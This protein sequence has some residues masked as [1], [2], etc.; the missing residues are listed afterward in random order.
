MWILFNLIF[1][2]I[3]DLFDY[4]TVS[5]F[6]S[7]IQTP[8]V[9]ESG[10]QVG[11]MKNHSEFDRSVE[12]LPSLIRAGIGTIIQ[13]FIGFGLVVLQLTILIVYI[14]FNCL[15][16][17]SWIACAFLCGNECHLEYFFNGLE[18]RKLNNT[19]GLNFMAFTVYFCALID[20]L[21]KN[22]EHML[23]F[24][25]IS[26]LIS[27]RKQLDFAQ[28]YNAIF[29]QVVFHHMYQFASFIV[30]ICNIFNSS[31]IDESTLYHIL[32]YFLDIIFYVFLL[33]NMV[34]P[35]SLQDGIYLHGT[36]HRGIIIGQ[37]QQG[38]QRSDGQDNNWRKNRG[39]RPYGIGTGRGAFGFQN[40]AYQQ[41]EIPQ[42][43]SFRGGFNGGAAVAHPYGRPVVT[44]PNDVYDQQ[45]D[46]QHDV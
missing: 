26:V 22:F 2:A 32:C 3:L 21:L 37:G 6:S 46:D 10:S 31:I 12:L 34:V 14:Q 24:L 7:E 4:L 30:M 39:R 38:Y 15:D 17:K 11:I 41:Q 20:D 5:N 45:A 36:S 8:I 43:G 33:L 13:Q 28:A 23:D 44:V 9:E 18:Q 35:E 27:V 25:N 1:L 29:P 40:V 16:C 42:G 19:Y